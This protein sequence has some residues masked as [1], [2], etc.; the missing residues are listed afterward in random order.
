MKYISFIK[1]VI[2]DSK[3][4]LKKNIKRTHFSFSIFFFKPLNDFSGAI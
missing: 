3:S 4:R 2:K 1:C